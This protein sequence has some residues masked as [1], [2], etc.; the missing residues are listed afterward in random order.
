MNISQ[1]CICVELETANSGIQAFFSVQE[2][3]QLIMFEKL[4]V[5][6]TEFEDFLYELCTIHTINESKRMITVGFP[7]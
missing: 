6:S 3:H 5:E 1:E 4:E 2:I 7:Q